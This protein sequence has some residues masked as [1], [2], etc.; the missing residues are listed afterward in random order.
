MCKNITSSLYSLCFF[1]FTVL[2]TLP[3]AVSAF[4]LESSP[5][6]KKLEEHHDSGKDGLIGIAKKVGDKIKKEY[7]EGNVFVELTKADGSVKLNIDS[8]ADDE[9]R[10]LIKDDFFEEG[11]VWDIITEEVEP[12][13][14]SERMKFKVYIQ[15]DPVGC[16][17]CFK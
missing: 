16:F 15:G 7:F 13:P 14:L 8:I 1:I 9:L 2:L 4:F 11:E 17:Y 10:K 5:Y 6:M 3:V 12:P